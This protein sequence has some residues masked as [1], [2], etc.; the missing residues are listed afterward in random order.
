MGMP[1]T[2]YVLSSLDEE[3]L[4]MAISGSEKA[5]LCLI[6]DAVYLACSRGWDLV[7]QAL[8]K[9]FKIYVSR[10]DAEK[11]GIVRKLVGEAVLVGYDEI[12]DLV[13]GSDKVI[14]L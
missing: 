1:G 10:S 2:L 12:V 5:S 11:R 8:A 6:Q 3:S 7:K 13:F 9:G 14:N 4:R